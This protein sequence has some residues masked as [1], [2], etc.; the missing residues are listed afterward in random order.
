MIVGENV[1]KKNVLVIEDDQSMR[2]IIVLTMQHL[3]FMV[4][5]CHSVELALV[6]FTPAN[7]DLVITDLFMKGL[8][9]IEGIQLMRKRKPDVPIIAISGGCAGMPREM[10][11]RA[12]KKIGAD[13]V[14]AKPFTVERLSET[15]NGVLGA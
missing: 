3:G 6:G 15:V 10:A 13:E 2:D 4:T 1:K 14:L 5:A 8:G 7:Y 11:L 12:A 9:G